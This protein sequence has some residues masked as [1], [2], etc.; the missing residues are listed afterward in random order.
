MRLLLGILVTAFSLQSF[1]DK[2]VPEYW[3]ETEVPFGDVVNVLN[4][5]SCY[6]DARTFY[7]CVMA[8]PANG[9]A[10]EKDLA[11]VPK[12]IVSEL[13]LDKAPK[14]AEMGG[15]VLL[16]VPKID[17]KMTVKEML[18]FTNKRRTRVQD[19]VMNEIYPEQ[20]KTADALQTCVMALPAEKRS[21]ELYNCEN[22]V[23]KHPIESYPAGITEQEKH[24]LAMTNL[25]NEFFVPFLVSAMIEDL[26]VSDP[27]MQSYALALVLNAK[28]ETL[29]GH[30]L[31]F[32][33]SYK[34]EVM[35]AT[36]KKMSGIGAELTDKDHH[37]IVARTI[38]GQPAEKVLQAKDEVISVKQGAADGN[39]KV[40][41]AAG[42]TLE[43]LIKEIRGEPNT[44]V[45]L[46][47][48]RDG[49]QMDKTIIRNTF[50][51]KNLE[52]YVVDQTGKKFG[53]LRLKSFMDDQLCNKMQL[54]INT[55]DKDSVPSEDNPLPAGTVRGQVDGWI[56]DLRGNGGGLID[57]AECLSE[58]FA[59][60][61]KIVG[62]GYLERPDHVQYYVGQNDAITNKPMVVLIDSNSASASEIVAGALQDNARAWLVGDNSFGK[63]SVQQIQRV[64]L[65][66]AKKDSLLY[67]ETIALFY[68]PSGRTNQLETLFP[69][70][71]VPFK[72]NATED[73]LFALREV[74]QTPNAIHGPKQA[75]WTQPRP[76]EQ[77]AI[78]NCVGQPKS[79]AMFASSQIADYQ[80]GV[81]Q[82]VLSCAVDLAKPSE[83]KAA[84]VKP[85]VKAELNP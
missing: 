51:I 1:A 22:K 64:S 68:Q 20:K 53:Y 39:G 40:I 14:I 28:T 80:L 31:W 61:V 38:E 63:G 42:S 84:D 44:P 4:L 11:L 66:G 41:M 60:K 29:D 74:D 76:Q 83:A 77:A 26:Y 71:K 55:L 46:T 79:D 82:E 47:I 54:A 52:T 18:A 81:A 34:N 30:A 19:V 23:A 37:I 10:A 73:E 32:P 17:K 69:D 72:P 67:K 48:L 49:Q 24:N 25:A 58:Q 15:L 8:A 21:A 9:R 36:D 12:S 65:P 57:M 62:E 13:E 78:Q 45:T 50:E 27:K 3:A 7:A 56:L 16:E 5:P 35:D 85:Q 2:T 75:S 33:V 43:L 6:K 70:F 59:G